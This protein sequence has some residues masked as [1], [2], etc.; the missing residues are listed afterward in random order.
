MVRTLK[1]AFHRK[2]ERNRKELLDRIEGE[3]DSIYD[4]ISQIFSCERT[5]VEV[6]QNTLKK[7][8][9]RSRHERYERYL[10]L[11]IFRLTV[12]SI[13]R[14]YNRFLSEAA[15][16]QKIP[17]SFLSLEEK[18]VLMLRD[19]VGLD[20]EDISC[21]MQVPVSRVGRSITYAREKVAKEQL[22]LEW[23]AED[24]AALLSRVAFNKTFDHEASGAMDT[25]YASVIT[26]VKAHVSEMEKHGFSEIESSVRV[27]Q[28]LPILGRGEV[29]RWS[30]MPWHYKLS[31]EASALALVGVLAV[32]VVPW[33]FSKVN[34]DALLEG[35]V[36]EVFQVETPAVSASA[37]PEEI[38]ADRLLASAA[39]PVYSPDTAEDLAQQEEF[40]DM[41]FPSGDSYEGGAAPLA[42]S[43][44][45]AA[46]YRLILLSPSPKEMIPLVKTLFVQKNVKERE[47][48]GRIMPGGVYFDG[49]TNV[50]SY[51]SILQ[52][53]QKMG[54]TKT[55]SN[56]DQSKNPAEK[57]R[58]IVWVQQ[59]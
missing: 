59:I 14:Q 36:T 11:W 2:R 37:E 6:L 18:L 1:E 44:Q 45:R 47:I 38:T 16:G 46:V 41:D 40:A 8:I 35:R 39:E 30:E 15:V 43:K 21:V 5:N 10:Q 25:S 23:N 55:H 34:T 17:F 57:A 56:P 54:T 20:Y 33:A 32:V 58:V 9:G 48:S 19:R 13:Q 7:A 24:H 42:P 4:L 3:L 29:M 53:I 31:L 26:K 52:E 50:G 12:E 22:G 27:H 49:L 51:P 28:I